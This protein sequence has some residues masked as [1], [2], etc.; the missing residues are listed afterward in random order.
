MSKVR[1]LLALSDGIRSAHIGLDC[2][3]SPYSR[4]SEKRYWLR[5]WHAMKRRMAKEKKP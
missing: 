4:G 3:Y 5:G 1:E 2:I